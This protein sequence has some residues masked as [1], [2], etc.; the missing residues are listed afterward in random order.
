MNNE[1]Y[2]AFEFND[3]HKAGWIDEL[4]R[5]RSDGPRLQSPS[6]PPRN[7]RLGTNC[8][9]AGTYTDPTT[10]AVGTPIFQTTTFLF[11][12]QTYD[13]FMEGFTRDVLIYSRYGNPNHWAVQQKIAALEGAESA[14]LCSSGM[15]AISTTILALSNNGGH[16]ISSN[17]VYGGTYNL[18][19]EDLHQWG[20]SVSFVDGTDIDAIEEAIRPN[21][22]IFFFETLTNPLL[23][24][25]PLKQIIALAKRKNILVV[26]DN[27][28]LSPIFLR[29][30]EYGADVVIHSC[31]KYL[32]GHSDITAGVAS[33]SRKY[34]D[35]IWAQML[36]LGGCCDPMTAFLLERGLKT[37]HLRMAAHNKNAIAV[38]GILKDSDQVVAVHHP[39]IDSYSFPWVREYCPDGFGGVVSFEIKGGNLA[40]LD[41]LSRLKVPSTATSLGGVESLV[42]LPFNTSHNS[43]TQDQQIKIGIRP[44]LIRY[45]VGVEDIEDIILDLRCALEGVTL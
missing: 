32:N 44:G 28:F 18:L 34:V 29:P 17:D 6:R 24:A 38:A 21:T 43:L 23:K 7:Y 33:G 9:H 5:R 45:S 8:I 1:K 20:R 13:A 14:V 39:S 30:I 19:R 4:K 26:L 12:D 41:L 36:K 11:G 42:S 15:A 3:G 40:A 25:I 16:I 31:T 27:T 22:Q 10:G 35:R 2:S 37:L